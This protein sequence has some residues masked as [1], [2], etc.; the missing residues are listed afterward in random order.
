[1]RRES[2]RRPFLAARRRPGFLVDRPHASTV[3]SSPGFRTSENPSSTGD[4]PCEDGVQIAE[5][6]QMVA[7]F[8]LPD[9]DTR[10]KGRLDRKILSNRVVG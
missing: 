3:P 10:D 5:T 8:W 4:T 6:A 1:M 2:L 9:A 7:Q